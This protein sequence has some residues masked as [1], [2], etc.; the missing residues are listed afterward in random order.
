MPSPSSSRAHASSHPEEPALSS[1]D[2]QSRGSSPSSS[3]HNSP[4]NAPSNPNSSPHKHLSSREQYSSSP[5]PNDSS[6]SY[7]QDE[8]VMEDDGDDDADVQVELE[9]EI[10]QHEDGGESSSELKGNHQ[11]AL[12]NGDNP[13]SDS[14]DQ[15]NMVQR[16][17]RS[18]QKLVIPE[19][20]RD[21]TRYF[22]R[23]SRPRQAPE[24]L[25]I[26]PPDSP[27]ASSV[28]SDSDYKEDDADKEDEEEEVYEDLDDDDFT[29]RP[30]RKTRPRRK[31]S[32]S[33]HAR[34]VT[35]SD[36]SDADERFQDVKASPS[37]SDGDWLMDGTPGKH[38]MKRKGKSSRHARKRRR[39]HSSPI[40]DEALRSTRVNSRTGGTVNYFEGDDLSEEEAAILAAKRA[41]EAADANIPGVDQVLDYRV[42][43]GKPKASEGEGPYTDFVVSSIEFKIKWTNT[44]FRKCT[45]ATWETLQY[46]KGAKKVSNFVKSVEEVKKY[47]LS[48]ATPE[49]IEDLRVNIEENRELFR[50]YEVVDRIIAQRETEE[51]GTEYLVKWCI[52]SYEDCTWEHRSDLSTEADMKAVDAF[53][54]R[55][56]AVL[57]VTNKKR[58]NPFNVKD[59]RPKMKRM[60]E[61]PKF[62]HGEGR[63]LRPYQLNGLNF[64]AFAW[65]KRNNVILADEMGL[66]KTLQTISF[67]GWLM[68]ARSIPGL[69]LVVVPLSTIAG[70]VREFARWLPDMNVI[71]YV[72]NSKSRAMI[73]EYEFFSSTKGGTEKFHTLLTTPELLMQDVDYLGEFRWSMIAVDEAH[74]LKNET[75]ALHI[76]LASLRSA[77]RLLVTGTPL[78]NSVRELWALLHFLN[79]TKFPS[80]EAFEERFS[81]SAL[82]DPERVSELHNALRPYIIRRQKSD[83]EK[84]LPKKTYAVLRVGMTSAQQ[85][86][87]RWLLTKNLTK[88]N[89][90]GK[91]RGIGNTS[92]IRNL[93]MELKKCCNH[94]YLFPN[95]EDTSTPTAVEE[96]IRA[97]GKMI[98]LDKLLLRLKERGHR[99][100]IFSQMVKML[101][102]LQDYCRMRQ[103]PFQRLDGSVANQV[104][105]RAVD[106]FNAPDST[107]F[108]F[109]LSTRA[110]GLGINLATADTVIIFD[111]D[112]NPQN[113]LQAE[114]RAH[115]I[116]QTKDVKVFRLLSRE[117]VEEDI[118]ERA[119][120]KR[121]L[122]HV[123]IHGVEGGSKADGKEPDIAFKK[124]ELSAIL[125]FGAEKLFAKEVL[126]ENGGD[127]PKLKD[128]GEMKNV[129]ANG[130]EPTA[131][132]TKKEEK[133]ENAEDRRVLDADDIDELLARAPTD[134]ASQVGAAQP[135]VGDSLLN[136][137][138]WN[139]FITVED[140]EDLEK[141][142]DD[143]DA[144]R[145]AKEASSRMIAIDQD[146]S[147]AKE[148]EELEKVKHARE[149]DAEFWDRVIPEDLKKQAIA[150]ETVVGTRRRKRPK[151]FGSDSA[152]EGK[153]RRTGRSG[154]YENGKVS[155]VEELSAKEQRSLLRSLRKFGDPTLVSV[156]VKDAGLQDRIE[157]DLAK[158]LLDDCL[159]Q[160]Q[161]AV[162]GSKKKARHA[163]DDPEYNGHRMTNGK[164]SKSKAARVQIDVLGESGVD[165]HDLLKRCRDLRMLRDAIGSFD[166]DL[167]F[168][169]RGV[170]K[171][172]SFNIRWKQY[173]D[174][175]LLVG[176]YRHG[177]GNWTQ[178]ARDEQL[179]LGDK[180]SV[181]GTSAQPGAPDTT[182]LARRITALLRELERE[183]RLRAV[184]RRGKSRKGQKRQRG[185]SAKGSADTAKRSKP[186]RPDKSKKES[187]RLE[188]KR[189]NL[190]T[191]RELR[192]L[193]KQS[194]K[195][196]AAE[197][198]SRTK[199][200]LLK[201]GR[202]I[203]NVGKS[204][205]AR[206]DLWTY[207]HEVCK[208][209]LQGERLQT[210]YEKLAS[211]VEANSPS[212]V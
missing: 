193:S 130:S 44:S 176:I 158:S 5:D 14:D 76:T 20:M 42:I 82:R 91:A 39:T 173:H 2:F 18:Q 85:Q 181:A 27:G 123:V 100:L 207:V 165:A 46:L 96:L 104:R 71:C 199:Q 146:V 159:S 122:E 154:R 169:L 107:D 178:I 149:G 129:V 35:R 22:R 188:I 47:V 37:D 15:S 90:A 170:I 117:T 57:T 98:L 143:T 209:S 4:N 49:E 111:S 168:R 127:D 63:T 202:S 105:Q 135:S 137:F 160:A 33:R 134:E 43:E 112:W 128:A 139:D 52:L 95:Y 51:I 155:D 65:T 87:Y 157:E 126:A 56:Q 75:S 203:D 88:L 34:L 26:S 1:D 184:D 54:D 133:D 83:V 119:K 164:D 208:T 196:E 11:Q 94:P 132:D 182:K 201:L 185:P 152:Q 198:I 124:E 31:R 187:M 50:S 190:A 172:P 125:R 156:I 60:A 73:R 9:D 3:I 167:K 53:S 23:S 36:A 66:G 109:L 148:R 175:M 99:V 93:L 151:T 55:E 28:G 103:F 205:T 74:R 8:N 210:I 189:C 163:N 29:L 106:H 191:L 48:Q 81:F 80:A 142:D 12:T 97:S 86:Y 6:S 67:L 40:D 121:V 17:R 115:R 77:N 45:W 136:A 145:M 108:I 64:L 200:C 16:R 147:R 32:P 183:S 102:I 10:E 153:R 19:D 118:L 69:F 211:T 70:W 131:S 140:D 195:L 38:T 25:S 101:D 197:R 179:D 161:G 59:D 177:F 144:K 30:S 120:R 171:P 41:E 114:S 110:G 78:Q 62:L 58:F 166:S 194:N 24:R 113:D 79:P 204:K 141:S 89:E 212:Q 21:D 192:S 138:K 180:M 7:H 68:Y 150:N 84:S 186:G 72:G 92:S 162:D 116:G 206:A 174:A 13:E 61:Q